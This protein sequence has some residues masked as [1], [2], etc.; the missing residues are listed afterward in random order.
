MVEIA[1]KSTLILATALGLTQ[2]LRRASA[3]TRHLIWVT[4][5]LA[6]LALPLLLRVTPALTAVKTFAPVEAVRVK[7]IHPSG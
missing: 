2:L 3:S 6:V 7:P 5:T 4:A 1:L